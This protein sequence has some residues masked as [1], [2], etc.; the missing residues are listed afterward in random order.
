V[1][2][3]FLRASLADVK[4]FVAFAEY[5]FPAGIHVGFG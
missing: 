2:V 1:P 3:A 4:L 5:F